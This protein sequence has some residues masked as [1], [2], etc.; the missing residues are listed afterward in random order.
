[1]AFLNS[2]SACFF[3]PVAK[4]TVPRLLYEY[5]YFGFNPIERWKALVASV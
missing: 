4:W 1:M 3:S 5:G 2:F